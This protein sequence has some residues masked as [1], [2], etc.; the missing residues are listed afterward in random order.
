MN[1]FFYTVQTTKKFFSSYKK[2]YKLYKLQILN[3][4]FPEK[5]TL[6]IIQLMI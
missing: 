2:S 5:Q 1:T 3:S 4:G 6:M